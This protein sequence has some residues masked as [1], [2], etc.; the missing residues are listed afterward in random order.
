MKL[1]RMIVFLALILL[2]GCVPEKEIEEKL[3]STGI[4]Y[5]GNQEKMLTKLDSLQIE[6][7]NPTT[8]D[9][10]LEE[11]KL[12]IAEPNYIEEISGDTLQQALNKGLY[13]F[14]INIED[15]RLIQEKYFNTIVEEENTDKIWVEHLYLKEGKLRSVVFS[16][17]PDF[18]EE[19]F[20]WL[21]YF[22]QYKE[23]SN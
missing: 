20:K 16:T 22:D 21:Q 9:I 6:Y 5:L 15:S 8:V 4:Q 11:Y 14:F 17:G 7:K 3:L 23:E 2:I 18:E 10:E 12:V 19:L 1:K 13:V